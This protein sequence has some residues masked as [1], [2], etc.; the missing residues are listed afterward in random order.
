M[1]QNNQGQSG[2]LD[3]KNQGVLP[4]KLSD[5]GRDFDLTGVDLRTKPPRHWFH[6]FS[7]YLNAHKPIGH[8]VS[9]RNAARQAA[10]T[11]IA[12][13]KLETDMLTGKTIDGAVLVRLQRRLDRYL[14]E[15]GLTPKT[16]TETDDEPKK[17]TLSDVLKK[18]PTNE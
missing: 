2:G 5:L 17:P 18:G 16:I 15:L 4:V 9:H 6:L 11:T 8:N 1:N 14:V 7:Y 12:I 13:E 10:T 3:P